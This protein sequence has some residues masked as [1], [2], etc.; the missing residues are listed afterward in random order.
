MHRTY[1]GV[2]E[3]ERGMPQVLVPVFS[4]FYVCLTGLKTSFSAFMLYILPVDRPP[5]AAESITRYVTY[6][7]RCTS[8]YKTRNVSVFVC[9]LPPRR[10]WTCRVAPNLAGRLGMGTEN[11]LEVEW[12][13]DRLGTPL[14][15]HS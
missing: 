13:K 4:T 3:R 11:Y 2:C 15:L 10:L 6:T 9:M 12:V 5:H 14:P 1:N 8:Y 7:S